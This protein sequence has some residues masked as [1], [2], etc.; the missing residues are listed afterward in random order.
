MPRLWSNKYQAVQ[1]LTV[2]F[3]QQHGLENKLIPVNYLS[4]AL[5]SLAGVGCNPNLTIKF[6]ENPFSQSFIHAE[7]SS[8]CPYGGNHYAILLQDFMDTGN[9][10]QSD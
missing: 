8:I 10:V 1:E 6:D 2:L 3:L 9:V 4:A 7:A 5:N